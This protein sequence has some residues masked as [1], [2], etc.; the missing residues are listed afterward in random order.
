MS[1]IQIGL[2]RHTIHLVDQHIIRLGETV[3]STCSRDVVTK[4]DLAC[5]TDVPATMARHVL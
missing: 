4:L 1:A 2:I 5:L 3:W